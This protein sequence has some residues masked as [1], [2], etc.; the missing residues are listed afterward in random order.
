MTNTVPFWKDIDPAG[1]TCAA[2]ECAE[3]AVPDLDDDGKP[4]SEPWSW[5]CARHQEDHGPGCDGPL[6]CVCEES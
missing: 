6:N 4:A 1:V 2:A 3:P 5:V